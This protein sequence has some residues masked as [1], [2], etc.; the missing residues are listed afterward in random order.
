MGGRVAE[1]MI[2]GPDEVTSGAV[3]DLQR[4]TSIAKRMVLLYGMSERV[5]KTQYDPKRLDLLAPETRQVIDE[6]V[7]RLLSQSYER[8]QTLL[9]KHNRDLESVAKGLLEHE[10]LSGKEVQDC[11]DGKK[12]VRT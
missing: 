11:I 7:K 3:S 10:T 12:I 8:A 5:G 2:F 6:E 1:E 9:K 4:A